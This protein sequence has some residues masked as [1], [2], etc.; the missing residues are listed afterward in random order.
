MPWRILKAQ[1]PREET[2][3][4][5]S[6]DWI[7]WGVKCWPPYLPP[8]QL[9]G[10]TYAQSPLYHHTE[11]RHPHPCPSFLQSSPATFAPL[12]AVP[13]STSSRNVTQESIP[14]SA[15]RNPSLKPQSGAKLSTGDHTWMSM[16]V[17]PYEEEVLCLL[18]SFHGAISASKNRSIPGFQR[19][20]VS[21]YTHSLNPTH[22]TIRDQVLRNGCM[23]NM[24]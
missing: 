7:I 2:A 21:G 24:P 3:K 12:K 16:V 17:V 20:S 11:A 5:I 22:I 1:S 9:W 4:P 18:F 14:G 15:S 6:N 23:E 19:L 8:G 10:A 13:E